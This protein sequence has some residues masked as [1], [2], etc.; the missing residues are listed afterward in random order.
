MPLSS[1]FAHT[2]PRVTPV[3]ASSRVISDFIPSPN[4]GAPNS[5][6][7]F[8][9]AILGIILRRAV[10]W[11]KL[12]ESSMFDFYILYVISIPSSMPQL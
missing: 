6:F 5:Y 10:K 4:F 9:S 12:S 2:K 8:Q 3:Q 11:T 1:P 7:G